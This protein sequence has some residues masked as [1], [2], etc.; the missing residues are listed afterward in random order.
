MGVGD[1]M[2]GDVV[3]HIEGGLRVLNATI[4]SEAVWRGAATGDLAW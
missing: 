3:S 2:E 4:T 1:C